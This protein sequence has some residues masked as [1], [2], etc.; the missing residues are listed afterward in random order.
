[1]SGVGVAATIYGRRYDHRFGGG[2]KLC[3][4]FSRKRDLDAESERIFCSFNWTARKQDHATR[5]K[6]DPTPTKGSE[7]NALSH[8]TIALPQ[9]TKRC[10]GATVV[11]GRI[12]EI[13]AYKLP[14]EDA[15]RLL[16]APANVDDAGAESTRHTFT[17]HQTGKPH[18]CRYSEKVKILSAPPLRS[19]HPSLQTATIA[20]ARVRV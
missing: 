12:S 15:L 10:S 2:S 13:L 8:G 7:A 1:M 18:S 14:P 3:G 19:A 4:C 6:A 5:K 17:A 9:M 11:V 16:F 20:P